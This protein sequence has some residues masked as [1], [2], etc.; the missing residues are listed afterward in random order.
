MGKQSCCPNSGHQ[1]QR[2]GDLQKR[3]L[4]PA[5]MG[6]TGKDKAIPEVSGGAGIQSTTVRLWEPLPSKGTPGLPLLS[7][8]DQMRLVTEDAA[9]VVE[10]LSSVHAASVCLPAPRKRHAR[11]PELGKKF[12]IILSYMGS[13]KPKKQTN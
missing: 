8:F 5:G 7:F 10:Y 3:R 13:L 12:K 4:S 6:R 1:R 11:N 9:R 2:C